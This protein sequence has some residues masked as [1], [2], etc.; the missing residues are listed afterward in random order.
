M[1]RILADMAIV[2]LRKFG[3]IK[4]KYAVIEWG[5]GR[6]SRKAWGDS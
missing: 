6:Q 3:S 2:I 1:K 4:W 5:Y